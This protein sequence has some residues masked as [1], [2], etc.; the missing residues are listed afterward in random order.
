MESENDLVIHALDLQNK[1]LIKEAAG[2]FHEILAAN[3]YHVVSLYSLS[4]IAV[5]SG[6]TATALALIDRSLLVC[7]TFAHSHFA[8]G[9]ILMKMKK[10][11]EALSS[12]D[13]ALLLQPD[14]PETLVNRGALLQEMNRHYE[15]LANYE[16]L[17]ELHPEH[18]VALGNRGIILTELKRDDEAAHSFAEMLKIDPDYEYGLGLLAY[19]RLHVCDW[20]DADMLRNQIIAGVRTDKRVCKS[21]AFMSFSDSAKDHLQCARIFAEN[22][23]PSASESLWKGERYAHEKIKIAYISPDLREHPV[24]HLMTGIFEHHDHTRFETIAISLGIDDSS[25]LRSR[26][27]NSFDHFIDVRSKASLEIARLLRSME[28][29]IAIDLAGYTADSR[30]DIFSWRPA[31]IQIN[32][33]GYPGSLGT[34]YFDYIIADRHTIPEEEFQ[35]YDEKIIHLPGTYLPADDSIRISENTPS[36]AECGL[37][38]D[39]FV[40]CSFNHDY[41][42]TPTV[43][44]IWMTLL[45]QIKGSVLWLMKLKE[46]AQ[47]NLRREAA[48]NGIDPSRLIFATRVPR[49]EDHL[50]RYRLADLFLDT[51]PYNAH[52]TASDALRTGL[53][54]ITCASGNSFPSK[55][56]ASILYATD[57]PELV[58]SSLDEYAAL[59]LKLAT[60]PNLLR[61]I[62]TKLAAGIKKR[63]LNT[64]LF[65]R[66]LESA[67][68]SAWKRYQDGKQPESFAVK[69][70]HHHIYKQPTIQEWRSDRLH[71]PLL[72]C[73]KNARNLPCLVIGDD[74]WFREHDFQKLIRTP[75]EITKRKH[76]YP[77][78][79][80]M[81]DNSVDYVYTDQTISQLKHPFIALH[82]MIRVARRAII[83]VTRQDPY[84]DQPI[85]SGSHIAY[86][87]DGGNYVFMISNREMAKFALSLHLPAFAFKGIFDFGELTENLPEN[88]Q[89]ING[90]KQKT[91][92]LEK[93]CER[94]EQ[95]YN[96]LM[97]VLFK[98]LP[99]SEEL[100]SFDT[101][102]T[103]TVNPRV[104]KSATG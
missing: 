74:T 7:P 104:T 103:V 55:V 87:D 22:K 78:T 98:S 56:A 73:F 20:K 29:D 42:I 9:T 94:N 59:A 15:A 75:P 90:Y 101:Q 76:G 63:L 5:Q 100:Q 50:A 83:V 10:S 72:T 65:C 99:A 25:R 80:A 18:T 27:I 3:P 41:K 12:F 52:T 13:Q 58:T 1:G 71:E 36:R 40:F 44:T 79:I 54:V 70:E 67:Y 88:M 53:P 89:G 61:N 30:T 8:R 4:V 77:E 43:F 32:Y 39:A 60:N 37:P 23:F 26:I 19:A 66:H 62:K 47:T 97:A 81:A 16:R 35:H 24:A 69:A 14:Y 31:P 28:V 64:E 6:D 91:L 102:W 34:P 51:T 82:E 84:I 46:A 48:N 86:Y 68:H 49:V 92:A 95:K 96:Y 11:E 21:L 85:V 17:L 45:K 93:L 2:I 38:S 57:M 33:L